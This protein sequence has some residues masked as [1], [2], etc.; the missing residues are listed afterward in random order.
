MK[1]KKVQLAAQFSVVALLRLFHAQQVS[2]QA[3]L[4]C[5]RGTI[6]TLQLFF[7]SV[8]APIGPG[9]FGEF[10]RFQESGAGHMRATAHVHIFLVVVQT[11]GS[12]ARHVVNQTQFV[13]FFALGK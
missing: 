1:V 8:T 13:F 2:V 11:Q 9:Q 3:S 6:D 10:E 12:L 7:F 4:V 5:P